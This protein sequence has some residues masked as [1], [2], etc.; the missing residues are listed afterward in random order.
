MVRVKS[1]QLVTQKST[2]EVVNSSKCWNYLQYNEM[3]F[4]K[5]KNATRKCPTI[6]KEFVPNKTCF[7]VKLC[8]TLSTTSFFQTVQIS[9]ATPCT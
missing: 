9:L 1:H 4:F 3:S 2:S 7:F 6:S 8:S 5:E